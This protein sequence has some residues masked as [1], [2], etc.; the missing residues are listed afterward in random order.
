VA[1]IREGPGL[2]CVDELGTVAEFDGDP[3][4]EVRITIDLS[5]DVPVAEVE[6][7]PSEALPE[8]PAV[9]EMD[10]ES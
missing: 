2:F 3:T 8:I 9:S 6:S 5:G 4:E 1:G 10:G 7:D